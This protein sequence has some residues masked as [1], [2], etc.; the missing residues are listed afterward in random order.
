[1][2]YNSA[3]SQYLTAPPYAA[4]GFMMLGTAW[5]GDKYHMRSPIIVFNCIVTVVG[6]ALMGYIEEKAV[7][8]FGVFL[9]VCGSN[10]NIPSIM[11][12]QANNIVGQAK[13]AMASAL[14]VGLGGVGGIAG[15]LI[16]RAEDKPG[17]RP[18]II[19]CFA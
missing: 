18:G 5:L 9:F 13:R 12:Y 16:F 7:R 1:M 8:Y 2:G 4:A 3:E 10:S 19:A 17:Y 11:A 15:S 14:L 6:L